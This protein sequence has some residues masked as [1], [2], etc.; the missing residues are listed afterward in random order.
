[1][2][3]NLM[4]YTLQLSLGLDHIRRHPYISEDV[5]KFLIKSP[6]EFA[7]NLISCAIQCTSA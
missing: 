7:W 2:Q 5:P 6:E 4:S 3:P 1:M